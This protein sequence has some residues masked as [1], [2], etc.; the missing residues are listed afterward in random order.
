[1]HRRPHSVP[2]LLLLVA[3]L[4]VGFIGV[5]ASGCG[6]DRVI[7][8]GGGPPGSDGVDTDD[9]GPVGDDTSGAET[10]SDKPGDPGAVGAM[11]EIVLL[12]DTSKPIHLSIT[13]QLLIQAKVIDYIAG[14]PAPDVLVSYE[15]VEGPDVGGD[16]TLTALQATTNPSGEVGVTFRANHVPDIHY[17]VEL[18]ANGAEPVQIELF[19]T[20]APKGDIRVAL[21]YEGPISVKNVHLR[22]FP[23]DF[24]CGQFN[25]I[26][27]PDNV[28]ADNTLLGLGLEDEVVW[29]DLAAAEKYTV[30]ATAQSPAGSLAAAGCIDGVVVIAA[31]ENS[32][33]LTMYLLTLNPTGIYDTVNVFDFTGAIPGE[34]GMLV[35]QIV[36]L[37]NNPGKFLI[38]QIKVLV[39]T[40]VPAWVTDLAFSLFEDQ[41]ADIVTNW[42]KNESPSWIQDIFLIGDDLTQ[43]VDNLEMQAELQIS[44]LQNDYYVQGTLFWTGIVLYWHLGCE[45]DEAHPEYDPD[46]GKFTFSIQDFTNTQ[47]PMDI[48]EG[49]FTGSIQ[50]F[51]K[52]DIDNHTIKINYGKLILFVLNEMLLPTLTGENNLTDAILSFVN[53]ASIASAFSNGVLDSI[54]VDEGDLE[55]FCVDA[56]TF[57]TV[58]VEALLGNLALDSQLRLQGHATLLDADNDLLVDEIIDGVYVGHV[59]V[60]GQEG[61]EFDGTWEAWKK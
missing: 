13:D 38:D 6:D 58:P 51:D 9:D 32:V 8:V 30:V 31:E 2:A 49:K 56:I 33:T 23:G 34:L 29:T 60:D 4:G 35:D 37:F 39:S 52:F 11:R 55:G 46:C 42:I 44:K 18:S 36:L 25:P 7:A 27:V 40:Y 5:G 1:M 12:H 61:P 28:I 50:D 17:T 24:T 53:C 16:A 59:E 43:I 19:V 21:N 3:V 54:G 41:L 20:D 22:L 45:L 47:F 14:G 15:I 26:N 10:G 57:L 48:V